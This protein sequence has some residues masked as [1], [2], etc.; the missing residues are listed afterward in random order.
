MSR[1]RRSPLDRFNEKWVANDDGCWIWTAFRTPTGYGRFYT[2][3]ASES[4]AHRWAYQLYVGPIPEGLVLDHLCRNRACVNPEHLEPVTQRENVGRGEQVARTHCPYGH[5]YT[6]ENTIR[7]VRPN[8]WSSRFCRECQLNRRRA[9][10]SVPPASSIGTYGT[11]AGGT[12]F[13]QTDRVQPP[14]VGS[15]TGAS[16]LP[17]SSDDAP[18]LLPVHAE[19]RD[20]HPGSRTR[21]V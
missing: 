3:G 5:E 4:Y 14:A 9:P 6:P 7:R 10:S 11:R 19:S 8:G 12:D 13:E 15:I 21:A 20:R 16:S 18:V 17:R 1:A 2:V